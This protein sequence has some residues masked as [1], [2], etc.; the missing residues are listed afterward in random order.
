M[1]LVDLPVVP[2]T[3]HAPA[4]I[5]L[6]ALC[7]QAQV[8]DLEADFFTRLGNRGV[9]VRRVLVNVA[10]HGGQSKRKGGAFDQEQF[11]VVIVNEHTDAGMVT[12]PR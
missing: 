12:G 8:R 6:S 3:V 4:G 5:L 1:G 10:G 9:F 2:R 11:V 7:D